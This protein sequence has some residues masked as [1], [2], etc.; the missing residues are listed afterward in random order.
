MG[1]LRMKYLVNQYR[2]LKVNACREGN[3]YEGKGR[4][5]EA[6]VEECQPI[7]G[8]ARVLFPLPT[9]RV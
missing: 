5:V 3:A 8:K 4:A 1:L 6:A 9:H 2:C 7:G